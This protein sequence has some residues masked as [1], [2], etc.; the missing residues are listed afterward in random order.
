MGGSPCCLV[1]LGLRLLIRVLVICW[2][3]LLGPTLP[4]LP[5]KWEVPDELR[6]GWEPDAPNVWTDDSLVQGQVSG[7]S[8][9]GSGFY[10]HL[11]SVHWAHRRWGHLDEIRSDDGVVQSCLVFCSVPGPL[12]SVQRTLLWRV[13][14]ALRAS[15]SL[16][17]GVDNLNV[18]RHVSRQLDG[19][20]HPCPYELVKDGD[21]I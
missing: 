19:V 8:S 9:S 16:H 7:A 10:A 17:L 2:N 21:L 4:T 3:R 5:F 11:P 15:A 1:F 13:I 18:V 20:R 12:Q 14:L 6:E